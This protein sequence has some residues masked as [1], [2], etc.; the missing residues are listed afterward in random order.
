MSVFRFIFGKGARSFGGLLIMFFSLAIAAQ[1]G[2]SVKL[3]SDPKSPP[4][5]AARGI[6]QIDAEGLKALLH[7]DGKPL[8]INFWATWC[9]PCREEF[10]DLVKL[11]AEY[12]GKIVFLTVTLDDVEEINRAVPKFLAEMKAGMPTF[13]LKTEDEEVAI[14]AVARDWKGGLPF[15]ILF[16]ADGSIS[17]FR[18]GPI[19]LDNVRPEINKVIPAAK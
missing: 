5:N 1:N 14:K 2:S 11:D 3:V 16:G 18:Q 9:D 4:A 19:N 13:L 17:Y 10:P 12:R 6:T 7:P 8:L 15:T